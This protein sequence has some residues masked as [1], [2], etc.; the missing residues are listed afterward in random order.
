MHE[1]NSDIQYCKLS[2]IYVSYCKS[3]QKSP[4]KSLFVNLHKLIKLLQVVDESYDEVSQKLLCD[5]FNSSV[6]TR[7][8]D[9]FF[10]NHSIY[11]YIYIISINKIEIN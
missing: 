5:T 9:L 11:T 6:Y 10:I 3:Q 1:I 2:F 4:L 8:I 7:A